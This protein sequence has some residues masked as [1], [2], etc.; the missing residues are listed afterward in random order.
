[1]E[2][3]QNYGQIY[4][5]RKSRLWTLINIKMKKIN[6]K[7][8]FLK[9]QEDNNGK[10]KNKKKIKNKNKSKKVRRLKKKY[11]T[12]QKSNISEEKIEIKKIKK[13]PTEKKI[14]NVNDFVVYPQTWCWQNN[15]CG[16]SSYWRY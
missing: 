16:K 2:N 5:K 11:F 14:Y 13:Q 15:C 7:N 12:G 1:M 10:K 8:T 3:M 6:T 4:Q 9:N